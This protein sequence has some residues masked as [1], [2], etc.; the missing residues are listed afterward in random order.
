MKRLEYV[1]R[2]VAAQLQRRA[3]TQGT[4]SSRQNIIH[5]KQGVE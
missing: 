2:I 5:V 3:I 1:C 4:N